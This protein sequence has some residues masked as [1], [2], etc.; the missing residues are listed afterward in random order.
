MESLELDHWWISGERFGERNYYVRFLKCKLLIVYYKQDFARNL[1]ATLELIWRWVIIN[2]HKKKFHGCIVNNVFLPL[3][4]DFVNI[5]N[6]FVINHHHHHP[7]GMWIN[8]SHSLSLFCLSLSNLFTSTRLNF[9]TFEQNIWTNIYLTK[10]NISSKMCEM[11]SA[12]DK[13]WKNSYL[14]TTVRY[15]V[16]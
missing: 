5:S 13:E 4:V 16:R 1:Y 6:K 12:V 11:T 9:F 2:C 8:I 3:Y 10:K 15:Q 7:T 14:N